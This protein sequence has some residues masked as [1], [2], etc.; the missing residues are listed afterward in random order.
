MKIKKF[1]IMFLISIFS[2]GKVPHAQIPLQTTYKQGIYDVSQFEGYFGTI[3]L[4]TSDKPVTVIIIDPNGT[5]SHM[6][7][8]DKTNE[9]LKLGPVK[10]GI[11]MV[12]VGAGEIYILSSK[13]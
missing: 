4:T 1:L 7:I 11:I 12:V 2:L 5:V 13:I 8:L 3:K 6:A 10:K 9:E